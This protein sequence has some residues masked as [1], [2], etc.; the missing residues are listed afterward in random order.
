MT[1][2]HQQ[3]LLNTAKA[4]R[5][6]LGHDVKELLE[7]M[8]NVRETSLNLVQIAWELEWENMLKDRH[9]KRLEKEAFGWLDVYIQIRKHVGKWC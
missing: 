8:R 4:E 5:H 1:K 3:Y 9:V 6:R 2:T 7:L